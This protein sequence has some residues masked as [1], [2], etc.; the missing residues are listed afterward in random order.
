MAVGRDSL[1]IPNPGMEIFHFG[2]DQK[3]SGD[4]ESPKNFWKS[5]DFYPP[6]FRQIRRIGDVDYPTKKSLHSS[7]L[8]VSEKPPTS[9]LIEVFK[10]SRTYLFE[11][12]TLN[13][14]FEL[15]ELYQ[16]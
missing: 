7:P 10:K 13:Y 2:L 6:D 3:I 9:T 12:Q 5:G 14:L 4:L 1:G 11:I 15:F 8:I 16:F